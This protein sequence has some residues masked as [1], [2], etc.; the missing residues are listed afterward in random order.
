MSV[1]S[2]KLANRILGGLVVGLLA[3]LITLGVGHSFPGVL[4]KAQWVSKEIF[5]PI[6]Q[7]FLRLPFFVII[8]LVFA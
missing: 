5:D 2:A 3:G 8:P 7:V 1:S 4:A 6:G